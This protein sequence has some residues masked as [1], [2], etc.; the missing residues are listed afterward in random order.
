MFS[1]KTAILMS[2]VCGTTELVLRAI[3]TNGLEKTLE[4]LHKSCNI[5]RVKTRLADESVK[6]YD[7]LLQILKKG[8]ELYNKSGGGEGWKGE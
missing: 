2:I 3:R 4:D 8:S 7:E 5:P 1:F 6:A